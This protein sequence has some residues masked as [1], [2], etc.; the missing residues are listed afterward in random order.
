MNTDQLKQLLI[1]F[2]TA[3]QILSEARAQYLPLYQQL[4]AGTAPATTTAPQAPAPQQESTSSPDFTVLLYE[5]SGL[6]SSKYTGMIAGTDFRIRLF[7]GKKEGTLYQG[8][9]YPKEASGQE[10]TSL[11]DIKV[12]GIFLNVKEDNGNKYVQ[13]S[14]IFDAKPGQWYNGRITKTDKNSSNAPDLKADMW[15]S[16]TKAT[17]SAQP[18]PALLNLLGGNAGEGATSM[19]GPPAME[20][21]QQPAMP[22]D[23]PQSASTTSALDKLTGQPD[24]GILT[25]DSTPAVPNWLLQ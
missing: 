24:T 18:S 19:P 2:E 16:G 14:V 21:Q 25:G 20:Q 7:E 5:N 8:V 4:A 15:V 9:I 6:G 10:N 13:C 1:S 11:S 3:F 23:D 22:W 12:G 17:T